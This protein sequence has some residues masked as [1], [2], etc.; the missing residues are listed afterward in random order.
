MSNTGLYPPFARCAKPPRMPAD[1]R[2]LLGRVKVCLSVQ[3]AP[4]VTGTPWVATPEL[5]R[6]IIDSGIITIHVNYKNQLSAPY[7]GATS[8]AYVFAPNF[9]WR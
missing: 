6:P 2:D 1:G 5:L 8:D 3:D 9:N 7:V 4:S